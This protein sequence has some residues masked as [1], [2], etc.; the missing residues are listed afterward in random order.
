VQ[1]CLTAPNTQPHISDTTTP[2]PEPLIPGIDR[3]RPPTYSPTLKA[4]LA[5]A[6]AKSNDKTHLPAQLEH[7]PTLPARADPKSEDAKLLGPLSLRRQ[8]NIRWR[9]FSQQRDL[10]WWPLEVGSS[11]L[12][13]IPPS[14]SHSVPST[15][16]EGLGV[17]QEIE[18]LA[19][20]LGD[21][22][23]S[24]SLRQDAVHEQDAA[25]E[26]VH[27]SLLPPGKLPTR[28][29]RWMRRRY[30]ELLAKIPALVAQ[31]LKKA[32]N[33]DQPTLKYIVRRSSEEAYVQGQ[34]QRRS[35]S[36]EETEWISRAGEA[37]AT[38]KG[39]SQS[40]PP[41]TLSRTLRRVEA[42]EAEAATGLKIPRRPSAVNKHS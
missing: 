40:S 16:F 13:G 35:T 27:A 34:G 15:G 24:T 18:R 10:T 33:K 14:P 6:V 30:R 7:P 5:A 28:S 21:R 17:V 42:A 39:V 25:M 22:P 37:A 38:M 11:T 32:S 1:L 31:P 2:R 41:A 19:T 4:I 12:A 29:R 23:Q 26:A 9:F 36:S 20:Q 3:S 8:V